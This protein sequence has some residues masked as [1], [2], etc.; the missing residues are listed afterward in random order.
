MLS[1]LLERVSG[2]LDGVR[3]EEVLA[4]LFGEK[5]MIGFLNKQDIIRSESVREVPGEALERL[6][7]EEAELSAWLQ[8][9]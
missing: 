2:R 3:Q 5:Q 1:S 9:E 6:E 4:F 7:E 8:E